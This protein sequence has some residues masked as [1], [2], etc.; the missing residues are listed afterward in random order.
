MRADRATGE[1]GWK[2]AG[3][4]CAHPYLLPPVVAI[5]REFAGG[6]EL[7]VAD[8]GCGNGYVASRLAGEGHSAVGVDASPEGV[9]IARE[10]YP[11]I[12]FEVRSIYDGDLASVTGTELD[13]IIALEVVEHL[14]APRELFA[15]GKEL[16]RDGGIMVVSTPYHGYLKNLAISLAGAWDSHFGVAREG[17]HIKFF[18]EG[19][20]V[21]M[22]QEAGLAA[23]RSLGVGRL[24]GLWKSLVVVLRK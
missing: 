24:P 5:V 20:L 6:R 17:G 9:N 18:S 4:S 2:D 8:L 22:A 11:G 15:R 21:R 13:C 14:Y 16:L 10:S 23:V 12:R 1:Y 3:P 7:R 19:T